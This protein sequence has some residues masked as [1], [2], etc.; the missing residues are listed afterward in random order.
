MLGV[1]CNTEGWVVIYSLLGALNLM[2]LVLS[3]RVTD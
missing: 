2:A 3:L 1:T